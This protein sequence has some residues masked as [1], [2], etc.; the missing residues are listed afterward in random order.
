MTRFSLKMHPL[1]FASLCI[2]LMAGCARPMQTGPLPEGIS[3]TPLAELKGKGP[4]AWHPFG[5]ML[6]AGTDGLRLLDLTT[7]RVTLLDPTEPAALV[8][9]PDGTELATAWPQGES[10]RLTLMNISGTQLA[11]IV[12][13]GLPDRLLWSIE[14]GLLIITT[15]LKIYSFGG[16]LTLRLHR[17]NRQSPPSTA[18]LHNTTIKPSTAKSWQQGQLSGSRAVLSP[19]GDEM[20]YLRL[21]DPPAFIGSYRLTLRHLVTD[22][23]K[24]VASLP[25]TTGATQFID[26]ER[27]LV[28]A[29]GTESTELFLW[30]DN[31]SETRPYAGGPLV[32]SPGGRYWLVGGHL[33][34][35]GSDILH[36]QDLE[37]ALFSPN[38]NRLLVQSNG[39]WHTIEG[40]IDAVKPTFKTD[41]LRKMRQLRNWRSRGLIT[42]EEFRHQQQRMLQP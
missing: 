34:R 9:S 25:L 36:I 37:Q 27:V 40:L 18:T 16:D 10:T 23:E 20:L 14:S 15:Q 28:D 42:P 35:D 26:D 22:A 4:I 41:D 7:G 32:I 31:K 6:A 3:I 17:W 19:T 2:A 24:Q 33:L 8:W 38:G 5:T 11:E 21:Q 13:P 39:N 30:A 1:L 12:V 29:G